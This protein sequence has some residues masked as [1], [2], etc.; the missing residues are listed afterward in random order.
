VA[1][2]N[3]DISTYNNVLNIAVCENTD[4]LDDFLVE[5]GPFAGHLKPVFV[6]FKQRTSNA[7]PLVCPLFVAALSSSKRSA[8]TKNVIR[9]LLDVP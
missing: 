6:S 9:R 8:H 1:S 7:S 4:E 2:E 5:L 3:S